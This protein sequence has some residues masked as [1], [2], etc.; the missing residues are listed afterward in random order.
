MG[1]AREG[2]CIKSLSGE[3]TEGERSFGQ[4]NI[5]M[6]IKDTGYKDVN[7]IEIVQEKIG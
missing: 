2:K 3:K 7:W 5:K 1:G 6:N 4:G